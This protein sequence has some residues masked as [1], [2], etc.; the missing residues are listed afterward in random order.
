LVKTN[1]STLHTV[2]TTY[3]GL[4]RRA[5]ITRHTDCHTVQQQQ[6]SLAQRV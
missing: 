6:P 4:P 1:R 2:Y 3:N 5:A